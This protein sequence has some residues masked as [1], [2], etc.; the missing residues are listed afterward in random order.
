MT[1]DR[2]YKY[3]RYDSFFNT[4]EATGFRLHIMKDSSY[5]IISTALFIAK[6]SLTS[7]EIKDNIE[8]SACKDV[9]GPDGE[10]YLEIT[11]TS[12]LRKIADKALKDAIERNDGNNHG[13][14]TDADDFI[15][16]NLGGV[17]G[18]FF[19]RITYSSLI[20][21]SLSPDNDN[22]EQFVIGTTCAI[23]PGEDTYFQIIPNDS[24][25][26]NSDS[27][28]LGDLLSN[29]QDT[30][31]LIT[32]QDP[33]KIKNVGIVNVIAIITRRKQIHVSLSDI[34]AL[35]YPGNG[36]LAVLDI[37]LSK[38]IEPT[39]LATTRAKKKELKVC[40]DASGSMWENKAIRN[41]CE[42]LCMLYF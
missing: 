42:N 6:S 25:V 5:E 40:V 1:H 30:T 41:N 9:I 26:N 7:Q 12:N 17:K 16:I 15:I 34:A 28:N 21:P 38:A 27:K 20:L 2:K 10:E 37:N 24:T 31:I 23:A 39:K 35:T 8:K 22:D 18:K 3:L 14:A 11:P 36:P 19:F 13:T 29:F 33:C 32:S 4:K